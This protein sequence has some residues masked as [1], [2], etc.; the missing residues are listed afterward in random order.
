MKVRIYN[1]ILNPKVWDNLKL[2]P[3]IKEKLLQI[4]KDFY[5]DTETD[6]P[7]KD[8]LFVGSLSNYNWTDTSDFDVHIVISFKGAS[9]S[10]SA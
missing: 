1:D 9:V 8:I 6:A 2:N 10:V 4:G 5:A 7:L 3:E